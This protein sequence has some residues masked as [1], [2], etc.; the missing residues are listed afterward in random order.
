MAVTDEY[1][2]T[3][4]SWAGVDGGRGGHAHTV[5]GEVSAAGR[6]VPPA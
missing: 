2:I 3:S 5:P 4:G 6:G 1:T